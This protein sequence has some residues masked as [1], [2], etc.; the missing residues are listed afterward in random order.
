[1]P[2]SI[3]EV[4]QGIPNISGWEADVEQAT[5]RRDPAFLGH[6]PMNLDRIQS[7]FAIALHNHQ[8]LVLEDGDLRNAPMIG[9]LQY[10]MER[11][12][13]H[14]CHDAPAYAWCY[15]RIADFIRELVHAGKNPRIMLDYP[16]E[17]L[18]GL[19]QMGRGDILDNLKSV[20]IREPYRYCVEWLGTMWGHAVAGSTPV[21]DLRLHIR[22]WQHHF[23][24][25][26][27]FEAL[28][29]VRGFSPPE[30]SLP[31]HPDVA[32]EYIKALRDS[33][34]RWMLVQ[35]HSVEELDGSG[36]R[37]KYLPRRLVAK[38]S[39]G[40]EAS[41]TALIKTQGSDT[42]LVGHMQPLGEARSLQP[43][44]LG[45]RRV[46][47]LV[48]QISDGENGGVM[49]N[50]FP[51]HYKRVWYELGT[52]GVVGLNGTEY[53]ELL[54]A[55]GVTE[56]LFQPVQPVHQGTVWKRVGGSPTPEKVNR[57][58]E[59]AKRS[60]HRFMMEGGSWTNDI[61]WVHGYENVLD[62]M[63]KLSARFHETLDGRPVETRGHAYRN[64]LYH[65]LTAESSDYRYWGQ[66]RW[67]DIA[68]EI[69]RRGGDILE[70]DF[71]QPAG[72]LDED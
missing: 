22:A 63:K 64:A 9:N 6:T 52:D 53:L 34:Y 54:A 57:A 28:S 65:L 35:E 5:K 10:M 40:E 43:R 72:V 3:P 18:F 4:I 12:H 66:G 29:R 37:E 51:E 13:I 7:A 15:T 17:L 23:A 58:I 14:G 70:Y 1:V 55:H 21:P 67:T 16:G 31:N 11:K 38:N 59:E 47:P 68:R 25:I 36:L 24:A 69:V 32:Y 2:E 26:F 33:G 48:T 30:M 46:P 71:A 39:R 19:R 27:G 50:E 41:I 56:D 61:S 44:Q 42:K 20:T 45:G 60:D 8:P 49:M 62:P